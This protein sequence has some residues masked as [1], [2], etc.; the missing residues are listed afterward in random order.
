M[1]LRPSV[2]I[3]GAG[4][5]GLCTALE[6]TELGITDVTVVERSYIGSGSSGRSVGAVETQYMTPLDIELRVKSKAKF[7]ELERDHELG[8]N[9]IGYLRLGHS[10]EAAT[11][12]D[13]SVK[14]QKDLGIDDACVLDPAAISERF[15]DIY[16][17]DLVAGLYGASDGIVDGHLYCS[18]VAELATTAGVRIVQTAAVKA[19]EVL[20]GGRHRLGTSKGDVVSEFVVNAAGAWA[21]E[22]G[23]LLGV[24]TPIL[25]QR[26]EV[27]SIHLPKPLDYVMPEVMDYSPSDGQDGLYFRHETGDQLLGG[28]HSE[29]VVGSVVDPNDYF[30]GV[31]Q[32]FVEHFSE[33]MPRR[34]PT[35]ADAG[36][37][38]GWAGLYP[39]SPDGQPQVGPY[40]EDETIIGACGVGGYG[41]QV[42]PIVGRMAA[43]WIAH[44]EVRAVEG[45]AT[46]LPGRE[47][48]VAGGERAGP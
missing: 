41:I 21:G 4:V 44:G 45:A 37:G 30:E 15:P 36:I 5:S 46:F 2:A 20:P 9:R 19:H 16:I 24:A 48:I 38:K 31:K 43:E 12:F 10:D 7:F 42:S 33:I 14:I 28:L 1:T 32:D 18:L 34:L 13:R 35:F 22:V 11:A 25:P 47:S 29:E 23:G 39:V 3:V 17:D 8:F 6:L 26:H 27:V 40:P